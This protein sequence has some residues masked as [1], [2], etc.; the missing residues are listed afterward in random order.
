MRVRMLMTVTLVVTLLTP[1][2]GVHAQDAGSDAAQEQHFRLN[3]PE[4]HPDP[5][6]LP[7]ELRP[8]DVVRPVLPEDVAAEV[9]E[10]EARIAEIEGS[11]LSAETRDAQDAAL[12]EAIAL[13]ER[14]LAIRLEHQGN[15]GGVVRWRDAAGEPREWPEVITA[16]QTVKDLRLFLELDAENRA[17]LSSIQGTDSEYQSLSAEARYAD[18]QAVTQLQLAT[19]RRVLGGGHPQTLN[20][21][22]N[23]GILLRSQGRASEAEPY[24]QAAL[25]GLTSALGVGHPD[26][27]TSINNMGFFLHSEGRLTEAVPY[28]REAFAARRRVL[29]EEHP[30]TLGSINN[31]G[32]LLRDQGR[33][34]DAEPYHRRALEGSRRALGD[35]HPRTLISAHNMGALLKEQGRFAEAEPYYREALKGRRHVLGNEHPRTLGSI[36]SMG[37][38]LQTQGKLPESEAYYREVLE[39]RRRLLGDAHP[40]TVFSMSHM[41]YLLGSIGRLSEAELYVRQ[42]LE[43]RRQE[44]GDEHR[45]TLSSI[46][47]MGA[48][49]ELQGRL[50]EAEPYTREA[51]ESRRRTLGGEHRD[52]LTSINNMGSLLREQGKLAEAE[53]YLREAL[54]GNR[55]VR[56]NDHPRTLGSIGNMGGL[57]EAQGK[58]VEAES[59]FREAMEGR[60]RVLGDAHS[61]TVDSIYRMGAQFES[62]GRLSEAEPY[63]REA[64]LTAESLRVEIAG[65]ASARAQF[66]GKLRLRGIASGYA[67]T[68]LRLGRTSEALAVLERGRGR[69]GLDLFGG[70]R[71]TAEQA[72]RSSADALSLARYDGALAAEENAKLELIE[73]E[74]QLSKALEDQRAERATGVRE[75]RQKLSE[76]TAS[77]FVELRGLVPAADPLGTEQI[78]AALNPSEALLTWSW[79]GRG[80]F[81]IVACDG[82]VRGVILADGGDEL[83]RLNDAIVAMRV[84]IAAR[85]AA[86]D[87]VGATVLDSARKAALP[88]SLRELL[89][90][91]SSVIA[92][93]EGPLSGLPIELL[94]TDLPVSYAPSATIALRPRLDDAPT[95]LVSAGGVVVGDPVFASY[96]EDELDYPDEGILLAMVQEGSNADAAGL[97][98]GDVLLSYGQH[99]LASAADLGPA[100]GATAEAMATRGASKQD[101]PVSARVWRDGKELDVSLATGRM[102]VGL[103]RESPS[104]GLRSMATFDRSTDSLAAN[105]T[106]LEQVRFY[107][108][109]LSPLPATRLEA[110]AIASML[111]DDATLLMGPDATAPRLREAI[112]AT[113][114]RVVHL[115]TH[116]LMGSSD[117]PLLASVALSTPEEPS[118]EDNGFVTLGDILSTWGGRLKGTELVTLSACD[119]ASAVRQG[120]TMMALPLGL[121]VAGTDT[122][123]ASLWK[124][125]D[126]ATALLMARFYANWLGKAQSEREIDGATYEPSDAMPK[127]AALREAQAWLRG[128]T[129]D[130]VE[131]MTGSA[132]AVNQSVT[133]DPTPR[134]GRLVET[135]DA[136]ARPYE[137]PFYW[138]AFVLY[139]SP[140]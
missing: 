78:L 22:G 68:L 2:C 133:R 114:P 27:L 111:G 65:D 38:L 66:A 102:G 5:E 89:A 82:K 56:G 35:E 134:R 31:M 64:M 96:Q 21:I 126:K 120:D 53:P 50:A 42:V 39:V 45:D 25:E 121:L 130:Q 40:S 81:A 4:W 29:G 137:H 20:S 99:E 61:D 93:T 63:F 136:D 100:I 135:P 131:A 28:Y 71:D 108:G 44:L 15:T 58:L 79:T 13:A 51:L 41:G 70:G 16:R 88:E 26:T 139:G 30:A 105:A 7:A 101:R 34:A 49:L 36:H 109:G 92:V 46:S 52:T 14:V 91:S 97:S 62:Q 118:A 140:E 11:W 123:V 72:L 3:L 129:R 9:A 128:L 54:A 67:W 104:A 90:G 57:L 95:D 75:A 48:L 37:V 124:V 106:A 1:A 103:S 77:I 18:A 74:T 138:A 122:V 76:M 80:A 12:D 119:T 60:R 8:L 23:L 47:N 69:S 33:L 83:A 117:R 112:E 127:L 115:A 17:A 19:R 116:G 107:G 132:G 84:G 43:V 32:G 24:Y 125:D 73:A 6:S 86:G 55:R 94:L 59:Y 87:H 10:L 113:P 110:A 98:R 85:P